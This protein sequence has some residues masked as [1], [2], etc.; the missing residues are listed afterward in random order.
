[1]NLIKGSSFFLEQ[2]LYPSCSVLVGSRNG[3]ERE[4]KI[5][6]I[7]SKFV[8]KQTAISDVNP[9]GNICSKVNT[10]NF[11]FYIYMCS[12]LHCGLTDS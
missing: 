5:N 10:Y 11:M 7:K 3:F 8:D 12:H 6:H 2:K 9:L 4:F 1:L